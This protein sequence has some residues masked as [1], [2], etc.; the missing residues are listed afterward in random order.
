MLYTP[1]SELQRVELALANQI[2][3][4]QFALVSLRQGQRK[5]SPVVKAM[6]R[7][8]LTRI[9]WQRVTL[10]DVQTAVHSAACTL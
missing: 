9:H 2:R 4:E 1:H 3:R 5:P 8:L 6:R 7:A 10:R